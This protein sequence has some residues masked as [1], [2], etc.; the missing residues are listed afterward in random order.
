MSL[1]HRIV[2]FP[3]LL[4]NA[5]FAIALPLTLTWNS[6]VITTPPSV[7][8]SMSINAHMHT[9]TNIHINFKANIETV[10]GIAGAFALALALLL[11]LALALQLHSADHW[12]DMI[13]SSHQFRK[14]PSKHLCLTL[15]N[16]VSLNE[17]APHT[18]ATLRYPP[19][20]HVPYPQR[21]NAKHAQK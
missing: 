14:S 18:H 12:L 16:L 10:N 5:P 2:H 9:D 17:E 19:Q 3:L 20:T 13:D 11:A 8:I 7:D 4:A 15:P 1:L 6:R 21:V